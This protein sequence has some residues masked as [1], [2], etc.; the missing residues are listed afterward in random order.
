MPKKKKKKK[1]KKKT[2][3]KAVYLKQCT[4]HQIRK[5]QANKTFKKSLQITIKYYSEE[6]E[7]LNK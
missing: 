1:K 4:K 5:N 6:L 7:D 2:K 3:K